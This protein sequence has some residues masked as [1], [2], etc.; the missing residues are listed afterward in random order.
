VKVMVLSAKLG[1]ARSSF[2]W[3]F[4]N[5]EDLLETL[6]AH[7]RQTNTRA[8]V[9]SSG[10]P[11]QTITQAVVNVFA[12]WVGQGQFNTRLD[13]AVR[14]WARRSE[15][16]RHML[17]ASDAER[18]QALTD[19]FARFNIGAGE[20]EVRARILYYTQIGYEALDPREDWD[21]RVSRARDYLFCMTG[22]SP[23]E[24]D[25]ERLSQMRR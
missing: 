14:D 8:I 23:S 5:R 18:L 2:Y 16:V 1:T 9:D 7:W 10:Q 13:F 17:D 22:Q 19:M 6:L 21:T 11:A 4:E 24:G 20:A 25:I 12:S 15:A 3:Y